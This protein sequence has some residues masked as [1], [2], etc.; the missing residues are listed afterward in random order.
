M[1]SKPDTT[2]LA[3]KLFHDHYERNWEP[4][5]E[6]RTNERDFAA[7]IISLRRRTGLS[8]SD[9]VA[10]CPGNS[11]AFTNLK[12]LELKGTPMRPDVCNALQSVAIGYGFIDIASY[13]ARCSRQQT[14]GVR[15]GRPYKT[16]GDRT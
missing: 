2:S 4:E 10:I 5:R 13:F 11:V 12:N 7:A 16:G 9:F 3:G 8:Q 6:Y 14:H 15:R 1:T